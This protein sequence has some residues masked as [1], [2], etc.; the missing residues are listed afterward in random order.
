V[1]DDPQERF[2]TLIRAHGRAVLGYALRRCSTR[3]DAADVLSEVFLV[4]WRHLDEVPTGEQAKPW[5]FAVA[6]RTLAT[7]RRAQ[8]RRDHLGTRLAHHLAAENVPDPA[9]LVEQQEATRQIGRALRTLG[10]SDRE[11]LTLIAW[12]A[13]TPA[14]AARALGI[15]AAT[16]RVR[17]HRAR[18]R[19]GRALAEPL[20]PSRDLLLPVREEK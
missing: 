10:E 4:A 11:L 8:Q 18:A 9:S 3:D 5:L 19:L 13:L 14:Q 2:E 6:R 17:L 7:A 20:S 15:S 1:Q 16:A 12:E